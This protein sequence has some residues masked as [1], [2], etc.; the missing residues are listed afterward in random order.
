MCCMC[1]HRS[2]KTQFAPVA[3]MTSYHSWFGLRVCYN[4][5]AKTNRGGE[6]EEEEKTFSMVVGRYFRRPKRDHLP[7]ELAK[8]YLHNATFCVVI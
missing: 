7:Q 3:F 2:I 8:E 4:L 5:K 6:E 1:C